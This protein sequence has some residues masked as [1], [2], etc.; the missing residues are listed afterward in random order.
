[1]QPKLGIIAGGGAIPGHLI[2]HCRDQGRDVFVVAVDGHADALALDDI[3]HLRT[4]LGAVGKVITSLHEA[5]VQE[6]VLIGSLRRPSLTEL[7]PDAR[8]TRLLMKAGKA[9]FGDDG[10]LSTVVGELEGEG[11]T[12]VGADAIVSELLVP[13]GPLGEVTPDKQAEQDIQRGREVVE[14]LGK[15]DLGQATVVQ[16]GYVL[17]IEAA[18]GTDMM[19]SRCAEL[20]REGAGGVLV[21]C[22]KPGQDRRVDLPTIGSRTIETAVAAGLRGI[23][24][25]AGHTML[26]DRSAA[27]EKANQHGVFIVGFE[28]K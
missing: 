4:R 28:A 13:A 8:G 14:G 25:E 27:V 18:E 17:A 12:V 16:D 20:R 26:V 3:P 24:V 6:I 23:A 2:Q 9:A 21:K 7:R 11:F 10:L 19:L 1:M 22:R 15:L 5:A